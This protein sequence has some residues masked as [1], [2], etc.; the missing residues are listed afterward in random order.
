MKT[1]QSYIKIPGKVENYFVFEETVEDSVGKN[2]RAA[3]IQEGSPRKHKLI[4]EVH[5]FHFRNPEEW[6]RVNVLCDRIRHINNPNLYAPEKI[7]KKDDYSLFV[8]PFRNGKTLA[9]IVEDAAEKEKPIPFELAF[10]IALAIATMIEVG[11]SI[12][13]KEQKAFHGFLTPDHIIIDYQGNIFLKCFGVWPLLDENEDAVSEMNWKYGS[14]LAPEFIRKEKVVPQSDFYYLGYILYRMLTGNYFSYLPGEDFESTFT[15]ISFVSDLPSTDIK[16]LT[17]LINFFKKTLNPAVSKRF[18]N[19]REFKNYILKFFPTPPEDFAQF[20]SG[21]STYMKALYGSSI[22][23]EE[24]KLAAE[25]TGPLPEAPV[26]GKEGIRGVLIDIPMDSAGY[27]KKE[28]SKF[29]TVFLI[30][31]VAALAV[32]TYFLIDQLNKAKKEQLIAVQMLEQQNKERS[33]FEQKLQDVQ[34]K[35]QSLDSQKTATKE[36]QQEKEETISQLKKQ[37]KELKKEGDARKAT[38]KETS[39]AALS[40]KQTNQTN[41]TNQTKETATKTTDMTTGTSGTSGTSAT[42]KPETPITGKPGSTGE[43]T[44]GQQTGQQPTGPAEKSE[45]K[46]I[47]AVGTAP[48][49]PIVTPKELTMKPVK[50]SGLDPEFPP[51]MVKTYAGRRATVSARLLI[52]ENGSVSQVEIED[53][54]KI[55][56]DVRDLIIDNFK[57]WKFK[58]PQK[59]NMK[60]RVWWPH[61]LKIQF[62]YGDI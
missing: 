47:S 24:E 13:V 32:G 62:K 39:T 10:S 58:P 6:T 61:K 2:F 7:L 26:V 38:T 23:E 22:A 51:A 45:T 34:Q 50:L 28:R 25:L 55:P 41:Q 12:V 30:V 40:P 43:S 49:V 59:D 56:A 27:G 8:F 33:E 15:S 52:D 1:K 29:L 36:E 16:F 46:E 20:K 19:I 53:E 60:V 18:A 5:S 31:I 35:L 9:Q 42:T 14:W 37:E 44:H 48:S 57:K 4:T 17:T 11:S 21:L 3:E 54:N